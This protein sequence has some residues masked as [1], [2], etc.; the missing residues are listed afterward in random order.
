MDRKSLVYKGM[1]PNVNC[2]SQAL[3]ILPSG[4][5]VVLFMTGGN[6]EPEPGNFIGLCRSSDAGFT[7]GPLETVLKYDDRACTFTEA[8]V[9]GGEIVV[10]VKTHGGN[11]DKWRNYTLRSRDN[12]RSWSEPEPFA[13]LPRRHIVRNLFRDSRGVW[14]LPYVYW[15]PGEDPDASI[16]DDGT[17]EHP[18]VGAFISHDEGRSWIRSREVR[19]IRWAYGNVVETADGRL[20]MLLRADGT[21]CLW[22]SD[23]S[24]R[25][26]TW[27]DPVRTDIPNPGSKFRLFQLRD[28]RIVLLHNPCALTQHP[29]SKDYAWC[30]RNPLSIWISGDGMA[31]WGYQRVLTDF[32]GMLAY[33]DGVVDKAE[34][35]IH[36]A[37]DY[38][39]H[40]VIYWG[41]ELP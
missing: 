11:H 40:D 6:R 39:R 1:V 18:W 28:G 22:R 37:F 21:G 20:S 14:I 3:R 2:C 36:F 25:G 32:P 15:E 24:D 4:E 26:L 5:W 10:F 38:N 9:H 17:F 41:A 35:Y 33:P 7:W 12:G 13:L 8:I 27:S 19:G 30:N 31:T 16:M 29:N 23:S 34:E